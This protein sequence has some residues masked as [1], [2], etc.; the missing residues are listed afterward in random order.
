MMEC[1]EHKHY[2]FDAI[3]AQFQYMNG[4]L[5]RRRLHLA[6]PCAP[7]RN[8]VSVYNRIVAELRREYGDAF[9]DPELMA[10]L[11]MQTFGEYDVTLTEIP[12]EDEPTISD[13]HPDMSKY[14]IPIK[15]NGREIGFQRPPYILSKAMLKHACSMMEADISSKEAIAL[16]TT[17]VYDY[18][19][20]FPESYWKVIFAD[21]YDWVEICGDSTLIWFIDRWRSCGYSEHNAKMSGE[22]DHKEFVEWIQLIRDTF[23]NVSHVISHDIAVRLTDQLPI[24]GSAVP[25]IGDICTCHK[26]LL[27]S[28]KM[29][30]PHYSPMFRCGKPA[31]YVELIYR[32]LIE[33]HG[34]NPA[35]VKYMP[36][37]Y[38]TDEIIRCTEHDLQHIRLERSGLL[39]QQE[40]TPSNG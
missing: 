37:H 9:F 32:W 18:D 7:I 23:I 20:M 35:N 30:I 26:I 11:I 6:S 34:G 5:A 1:G 27:E 16:A 29:V 25:P 8:N 13:N 3:G 12:G 36:N 22:V 4:Y 24:N 40:E 17:L 19:R 15:L 14:L 21:H 2:E 39:K 38:I 10:A 31:H 33:Q 28:D